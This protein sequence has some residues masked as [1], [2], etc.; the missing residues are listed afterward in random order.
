[1][2][3]GK[4]QLA[5]LCNNSE[6]CDGDGLICEPIGA[7]A[8]GQCTRRCQNSEQCDEAF[9]EGECV[10]VCKLNCEA[11]ADCPAGTDCILESCRAPCESDADCASGAEC[12]YGLCEVVG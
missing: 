7:S 9:G 12:S 1:M 8:Q 2:A 11:D 5:A 3:C 6:D 10:V 4:P